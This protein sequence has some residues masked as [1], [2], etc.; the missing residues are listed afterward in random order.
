MKRRKFECHIQS[1][2][3]G[4]NQLIELITNQSPNESQTPS[5]NLDEMRGFSSNAAP[6]PWAEDW[7]ILFMETD[8]LN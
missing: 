8:G 1:I 5:K 7:A 4:A 3:T 2:P 6:M